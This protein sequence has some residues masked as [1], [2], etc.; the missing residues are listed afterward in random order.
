M[1]ARSRYR[2]RMI[3]FAAVFAVTAAAFVVLS[4]GAPAQAQTVYYHNWYYSAPAYQSSCSTFSIG[5]VS[6]TNCSYPPSAVYYYA[7][8]YYVYGPTNFYTPYVYYSP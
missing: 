3:A 5:G 1:A 8:P 6:Y 7:T 2:T 4:G